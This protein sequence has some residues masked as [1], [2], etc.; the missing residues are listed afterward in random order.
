MDKINITKDIR[1]VGVNDHK[2]E[3]FEGQYHVPHGMSYNSYLVIDD[4]VVVVDSVDKHFATEWIDN[5]RLQLKGRKVDYLIINHMEPDHSG[6][7]LELVKAYPAVALVGNMMTFKMFD[8]FFPNNHAQHRLI[9]KDGEELD[10]EHHKFH[11]LTAPNV[12]W[13]EVMFTYDSYDKVL[14][15]ADAFGK[16]GTLD[17]NEDWVDEAKRYYFGIVGK[18][19]KNVLQSLIKVGTK[20]IK[21]ICPLHGPVLQTGLDF[22]LQKYLDWA[23]YK[24]DTKGTLIAVSSVYGNTLNVANKLQKKLKAKGEAVEIVDLNTCDMAK[25]IALAFSYDKLVCASITYNADIF[26]SM[27]QFLDGLI[28]RNYCNRRVGF[29]ENGTWAPLASKVM[30]LY[31]ERSTNIEKLSTVTI[32]SSVYNEADLDNLVSEL[33]K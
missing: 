21:A 6:S 33:I 11:F 19:G 31:L 24:A 15:S 14:F 13:P 2:I 20:E 22:Y 12:H 8:Q 28:S 27:R 7:I 17:F 5:I 29:I 30:Q 18:Y 26:P 3:L 1:Y 32:K 4:L 16:F 10:L 9:V 25:A 23:S